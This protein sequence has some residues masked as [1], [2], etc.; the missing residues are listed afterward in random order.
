MIIGL[1]LGDGTLVKK[2][3]N[4]NTYFQYA[5]SVS[6]KDYIQHVFDIFFLA[7]YCNITK[8]SERKLVV[9]DKTYEYLQFKTKSLIVFNILRS[10]FYLEDH[11]IIHKNIG[12][13]L[14]NI[15]LAY[16]LQDDGSKCGKRFHLNTNGYSK[17]DVLF[18]S[19]ILED[20]FGLNCSTQSR[21]RLYI[22]VN[23]YLEDIP[24]IYFPQ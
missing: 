4:G 14:T 19:N 6:H 11:K 21:N 3:K 9:K 2:Y 10:L 12:E 1:I 15:S 17:S 16:W 5:Q 8:L 24:L 22:S 20:K 23:S 7:G 13:L 18:L